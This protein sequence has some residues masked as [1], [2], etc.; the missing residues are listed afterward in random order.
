MPD[1]QKDTPNRGRPTLAAI[2]E[3]IRELM[4][5]LFKPYAEPV[6]FCPQFSEI[7]HDSRQF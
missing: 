1:L 6:N 4:I 7:D 3:L 5:Q 2:A